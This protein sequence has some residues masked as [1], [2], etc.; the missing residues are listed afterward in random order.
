[1]AIQY[2]ISTVN[3]AE[4]GKAH[5]TLPN[6]SPAASICREKK[7]Q[8]GK[9]G[10]QLIK[11]KICNNVNI[12]GEKPNQWE[13]HWYSS[14]EA[15]PAVW[16]HLANKSYS[17]TNLFILVKEQI[18]QGIGVSCT[19]RDLQKCSTSALCGLFPGEIWQVR[20]VTW[21]GWMY[22][23]PP[24]LLTCQGQQGFITLRCSG[25]AVMLPCSSKP[26]N[27][28]IF[29]MDFLTRFSCK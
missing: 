23:T 11:L 7:P 25:C 6:A 19:G 27:V 1:M 10:L 28:C 8:K 9:L 20:G 21:P 4:V 12:K 2:Q 5:I 14:S 24:S 29:V 13:R 3:Y 16:A 17:T 18:S 15:A 26:S 22:K